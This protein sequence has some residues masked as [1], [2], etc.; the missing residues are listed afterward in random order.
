IDF[1]SE[2][3]IK[4]GRSP[5]TPV[6]LIRWGTRAEQRTLLGT[7]ADIADRVREQNMLPPAVI[8]VGDVVRLREKLLWAERRPLFGRRVLVTRSRA[9]SSEMIA[10]IERL[11]GEAVGFPVLRIAPIEDEA[12]LAMLDEALRS[13][14]TYDWIVFTSV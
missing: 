7:L 2:Q 10:R 9:Q 4:Y 1:I 13:L 14:D 3:L 12:R 8:I 11:G 5:S 6:A